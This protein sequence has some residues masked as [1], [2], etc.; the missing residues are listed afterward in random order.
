M[1]LTAHRSGEKD[2]AFGEYKLYRGTCNVFRKGLDSE[3]C[4]QTVAQDS[5]QRTVQMLESE[6]LG[7]KLEN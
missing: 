1:C 4:L 3:Y 5:H 2:G 7:S 6:S